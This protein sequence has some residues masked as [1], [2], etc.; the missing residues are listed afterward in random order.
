MENELLGIGRLSRLSGLPVSALRFYDG[1]GVL[2]PSVVDPSSGYRYYTPDQVVDARVVAHLRR[3]SLPL[4]AIRRVLADPTGAR[5][6]LA[7]HLARLEAGLADARSEISRVHHLLE[8][9]ETPMHRCTLPAAELVRA[10]RE[11]RFAMCDDPD[12]PLLHGVL[13]DG[14][15]E[16]VRVVATDRYRLATSAVATSEPTDLHVVVPGAAVDE[17]LAADLAGDVEVTV[18]DGAVTL[19]SGGTPIRAEVP[20]VDFPSY[21]GLL[22]HGHR[23][24][25]VDAAALRAALRAGATEP[26]VREGDGVTYDVSRLSIGA[27]GVRVGPG[28]DPDA[29]VVAVNRDYLLQALQEG[30][31]LTLGLDDPI[32]PLAIRDPARDGTMSVLMPVRLDQPA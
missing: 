10:L 7:A 31:Q 23:T 2:P 25:P 16:R 30:D 14:E 29:L 28:D 20:D 27:D 24:V 18:A 17:L 5:P 9:T 6:V 22:D 1:A 13:L 4:D 3:V 26:H 32:A 19:T 8:T 21:E 11:V 15:H 12:Q